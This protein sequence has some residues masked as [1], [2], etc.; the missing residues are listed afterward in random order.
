M[1]VIARTT[2]AV[3][4]Y[5]PAGQIVLVDEDDPL[6]GSDAQNAAML[7]RLAVSELTRE[8]L[9]QAAATLGLDTTALRNR[10]QVISA[11]EE[12]AQTPAPEAVPDADSE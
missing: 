10:T 4:G 6:F 12:A 7:E 5:G 8:E 3:N 11:I 2:A 1:S 9:D